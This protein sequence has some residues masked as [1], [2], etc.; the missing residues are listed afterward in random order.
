MNIKVWKDH[1]KGVEVTLSPVNKEA[2][3]CYTGVLATSGADRVYLHCGH[4]DQ[5]DWNSTSTEPMEKTYR[6]WEK[7]ISLK[8][9]KLNFCFKDSANN[10]DN[11]NGH[12]WICNAD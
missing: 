8:N 2:T 7:K 5:S 3:I 11:N 12:N 10:W 6:G 1:E 9:K 4:G